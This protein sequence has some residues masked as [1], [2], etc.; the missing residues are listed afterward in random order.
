MSGLIGTSA[1]VGAVVLFS[2]VEIASKEIQVAGAQIDPFILVF[3]RF[4][5][6]GV[7]LLLLGLPRAR[8]SGLRLGVGDI[9]LFCLNGFIGIALSISLF[10]MSILLFRNASSS[11]VVFSANPV[12]VAVLAP[13][14]NRESLN[15][16]KIAAVILGAAG[17]L[18]FAFESGRMTTSSLMGMGLMLGAASAFALSICISRRIIS[19]YGPLV[20]MGFSALFGSLMVLPVGLLRSG[21]DLAAEVGAAWGPVLYVIFPGTVMAYG[22]Y[23]FGLSKTSAYRAS[24]SFFLK[25]VLATV[26]AVMLRGERINAFTVG[27]TFLILCGLFLAMAWSAKGRMGKQQG[28]DT[29]AAQRVSS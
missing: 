9:G 26:L 18:C 11:A 28:G 7:C 8:R 5:M 29:C 25:P 3:M 6:T 4:F 1:L 20:L 22:L 24:V 12:F 17:V 16:R 21:P 15:G 27:G 10:H 14:I 19:R 23:Y 13:L 2:T